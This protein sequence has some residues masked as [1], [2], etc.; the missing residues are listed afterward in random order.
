[1]WFAAPSSC[2][3]GVPRKALVINS[4]VGVTFDAWEGRSV[5]ERKI[6]A[7]VWGARQLF[8]TSAGNAANTGGSSMAGAKNALAVGATDNGGDIAD[9]SSRGPTYDGRLLPKVVGTGVAVA[10]PSGEGSRRQYEVR[11]GT[12][13][14]SPS[15]VGVAALAMDAVP[16]LREEPAAL[17]AH[18]M[19]SAIKPD[20]FLAEPQAFA[21][22]NTNGP[23][24]LQNVYGLGKVSARTAVLSRDAQDGW[25]GG[26][27][28]FDMEAQ[29]HAYHDIVV[30]AGASRLDVVVTWDEPP[31]E[32]ITD[33]VLHDLDL[34]V[35]RH[36][37]CG[38]VAACGR[39]QSQSRIDNVEWVIVPNPEPGIYRLKVLPNRI[40]GPSPRAGLAW[41]VIRGNSTPKLAVA[42]DQDAVAVAPEEGFDVTIAVTADSYVASGASV[43]IDC[44][45]QA[46]TDACR[47]ASYVVR[48]ESNVLREDG[49]ERS[50]ARDNG[51]AVA[52]GEIGPDESQT[53]TVRV[54]PRQEGSFRLHFAASAW[55]ASAGA[56]SIPVV[57]GSPGSAAPDAMGA[58][59][60]DD[61][62]A[63]ERLQGN[64]GETSF[65]LLHATREP[66]EPLVRDTPVSLALSPRSAW[67]EWRA[68]EDGPVRFSVMPGMR[69]DYADNVVVGVYRGDTVAGL[70]AV[71]TPRFGGGSTFF[72]EAGETYR[73]RLAIHDASLLETRPNPLGF[74][75]V[76]KRRST[77]ALTL[78]WAPA[79][80]PENDDY[81]FAAG[82]EGETGMVSGNNQAA[83]TE[84]G[85][86]MG[87]TTPWTPSVLGPGKASS[88]WYRWAAP[89]SGDWRFAVNRENLVVA[90][91][92][93][94]RVAESRLVSG[95]PASE[96]VFRAS[97]GAEYRVSVA[98][99]HAYVSGAEF[100]LTWAPGGRDSPAHDDVAGAVRAFGNFAF[101]SMDMDAMTVEPD[102]PVESGSRTMWV[103]W[104]PPA[105]GRFTWRILRAGFFSTV[106]E[107]PLQQSVFEGDAVE[108]LEL[109]SYDEGDET[110][111]Q[112]IAFDVR[113][114]ATYRL[115]LG[116]P[117][118]AAEVPLGNQSFILEWG[119]TPSNDD[120][121][122]AM[123]L[124]SSSGTYAGSNAFATT[125]KGELT[126]T[127][128][129]SS[130]WW[131]MEPDETGWMRF[132][133]DGLDGLKLAVYVRGEDGS[134]ELIR[135]GPTL[136]GIASVTFLAEAGVRYLVRLGAYY[137]DLAGYGGD[138][139]GDFELSWSPADPPA[140]LRYV[141][142]AASGDLA[143]DGTV[144]ELDGLGAQAFNPDGSELYVGSRLGI[145]VFARDAQTGEL[146]MRQMLSDYAVVDEDARLLWDADGDALLLATCDGWWRFT[147]RD[148][149]GIELAGEVGGAPCPGDSLWLR[150]EFV[151]NVVGPW[152]IE[153]Y[154]FDESREVLSLVVQ[155]AVAGV[156]QASMTA[157]GTN[158]YAMARRGDAD[159]LLAM[160][161]DAETGSL[162]IAAIITEG[163][164]TANE[165]TVE[166]LDNIRGMAVHGSHLFLSAQYGDTLVFDLADRV[167]PAYLGKVETILPI[168]PQ[169]GRCWYPVARASVPA[170]DI[171]C[172]FIGELYT[173]QVGRD[174]TPFA[175]D[176][177]RADGS[178]QDSFGNLVPFYIRLGS[179][180]RSP[181]DRH[182]YLA[183]YWARFTFPPGIFEAGHRVLVFESVSGESHETEPHDDSHAH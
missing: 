104:V 165:A 140:M 2:G 18:L 173:I 1:D 37:S 119:E 50:L 61:F 79:D 71:G 164:V 85:E 90:V 137:W 80:R 98:S 142:S 6:D 15:V 83:T 53:V 7:T 110:M 12:S 22:N 175:T 76:T 143:E 157:D 44:R 131:A 48:D 105:D 117:R 120:V 31:A 95:V 149:G 24:A 134:L 67:Y 33:P 42:A 8:V 40:H 43:R 152:M 96:A 47:D 93:G 111:D 35:D 170:A 136:G 45:A 169:F 13:M 102:E 116:L 172:G 160:E 72:A 161:R 167:D 87:F 178:N 141:G 64:E 66:G 177:V 91:Y 68:E 109:V 84:P 54:T 99:V 29:S 73:V 20:A 92:S 70:T 126:G 108:A 145:V 36:A 77:P 59:P 156:T 97:A 133:A 138:E 123:V 17:R 86:L 55:N 16:A 121:A 155:Q 148:E 158:V 89:S 100:E 38:P 132:A 153:T 94:E 146:T 28:A 124:A 21:L 26:T 69:G 11:S 182:L 150:D 107:A 183:S 41:T 176:Y 180:V 147:P 139:L 163:S 5:V 82:L 81:A 30:P 159:H 46:G 115:A 130:L 39:Y 9:F 151:H 127:L 174:G 135:A 34:W 154:E 106:G 4:S 118:D 3:D 162:S 51:D 19:A 88:V 181:D 168:P 179:I 101:V 171:V 125:E 166:G 49:T 23:G 56:A 114:D 122:N 25:T 78:K 14:A 27:A 60:N 57:I 10:A 62:A 144:V 32:T 65:D 58:P 129:D 52:L 128:G 74:G 113:A 103:A 112:V 75:T 63:A